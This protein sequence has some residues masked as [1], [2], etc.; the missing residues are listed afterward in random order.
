MIRQR[1]ADLLMMVGRFE[2]ASVQLQK[3]RRMDPFS[4]RQ[5]VSIA[6]LRHLMWRSGDQPNILEEAAQYG[7]APHQV[8]L[9]QAEI[10]LRMGQISD[11]IT[12]ADAVLQ[13][14]DQGTAT[15]SEVA[16][17]FALAGSIDKAE[18]VINQFNLLDQ[19]ASVSKTYQARLCMALRNEEACRSFL[20]VAAARREPQLCWLEIDPRFED[21]RGRIA[22][23]RPLEA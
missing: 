21:L 9:F 11:A 15:L 6:R 1:Y 2:E 10:Y 5:K 17:I 22:Y 13:S 20:A 23:D 12:L 19:H 7:P 4:Y 14:S 3:S 16:A 18:A 8:D